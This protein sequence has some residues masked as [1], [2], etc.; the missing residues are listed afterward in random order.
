[1]RRTLEIGLSGVLAV[2]LGANALAMLFAGPWWYGVVPGVTATG[3]YNAHFIK[4]IGA[5]YL[6]CAAALAA[7]A[8]QPART[9]PALAA[10]TVF[11]ILHAAIHIADALASPV[12]G[13]NLV[14]D[15]P[16]VFLPPLICAGLLASHLS[17]KEPRHA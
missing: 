17:Y 5:V 4:D 9:A 3:P 15:F 11:L 12:C 10:A 7:F 8:W 2:V 6:V 13:A 14:R 1:M 16:G